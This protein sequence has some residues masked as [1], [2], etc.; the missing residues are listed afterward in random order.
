MNGFSSVLNQAFRHSFN[1]C[2]E[3]CNIL[4]CFEFEEHNRNTIHMDAP[5][6]DHNVENMCMN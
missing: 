2:Y 5:Q 6:K 3:L 1:L 4:N